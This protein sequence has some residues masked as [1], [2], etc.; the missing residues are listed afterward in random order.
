MKTIETTLVFCI[1]GARI[2]LAMK[3]R[4]LGAGKWNGAGGKLEPGETP[5]AAM[6]RECQ[7]EIGITPLQYK[8]VALHDFILEADTDAAWHQPNY[9]YLCTEWQGEPIET[10][11]MR[12][13]WFRQSEIPYETMWPD[14]V[15]WLPLVLEGKLLKSTFAFASDQSLTHKQIQ[16]VSVLP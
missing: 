1:Q 15:D 3:K 13:Q 5:E 9:T 6:I 11:E 4:G 10:E 16:E 12:P 14:D 7:E 2:L 8:L